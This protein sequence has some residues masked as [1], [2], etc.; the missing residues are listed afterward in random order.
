MLIALHE[1]NTA[2]VK[3]AQKVSFKPVH[4][5]L[6]MNEL[7]TCSSQLVAKMDV[8]HS[9]YQHYFIVKSFD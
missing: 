6:L 1:W 2:Q 3:V 5:L 4:V 7:A 9:Y 8:V